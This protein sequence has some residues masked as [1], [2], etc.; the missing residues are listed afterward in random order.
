[1][2]NETRSRKPQG[3]RQPREGQGGE[4]GAGS[5]FPVERPEQESGGARLSAGGLEWGHNGNWAVPPAV[6][7][8]GEGGSEE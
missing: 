2:A 3:E 8:P 6:E 7:M 4:R 5:G 1:M